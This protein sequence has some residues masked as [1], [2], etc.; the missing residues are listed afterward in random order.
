MRVALALCCAL[1]G[2]AATAGPWPRDEG[3]VFLSLTAREG[4]AEFYGEYGLRHGLTMGVEARLPEGRRLPD[5]DI[6]ARQLIW[7]GESGA[8]LSGFAG[9]GLQGVPVDGIV[10]TAQVLRGGLAWGRGFE[11]PF[12]AGWMS[13]VAEGQVGEGAVLPGWRAVKL[14]ATAGLRPGGRWL[15]MVQLQGHHRQGQ[16]TRLRVEQ[17]LGHEVGAATLVISPSVGIMGPAD[18]RLAAGVWL[19][20]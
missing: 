5:V 19:R 12:G 9:A 11:T 14:D 10:E 7:Q 16:D 17:T 4:A 15:A 3:A 2:A 18:P 1:M 13:V 8:V 6:L 20:F